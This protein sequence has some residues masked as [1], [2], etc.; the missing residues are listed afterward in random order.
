MKKQ[1]WCMHCERTFSA[2]IPVDSEVK[3]LPDY[4]A[5]SDCDGH[6]WDLRPWSM[7]RAFNPSYPKKPDADVIYPLYGPS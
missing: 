6:V 4:C 2:V 3:G 1:I 7:V 5:Y